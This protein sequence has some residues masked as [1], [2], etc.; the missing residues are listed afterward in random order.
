MPSSA[1]STARTWQSFENAAVADVFTPAKRSAVM[2]GI[3]SRANA[4]TELA[5]ARAMRASGVSGW[6]RHL[7]I[8]VTLPTHAR[9]IPAG[10]KTVRPDFVFRRAKVVV[11][12]DGC[13]WHGC[14]QHCSRPTTNSAWWSRKLRGNMTRDRLHTRLLTASGWKVLRLWEHALRTDADAC[15]ARVCRLL[16]RRVP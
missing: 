2:S 12:V 5:L 8:R 14:P 6:R 11:F 13:F 10:S 16:A 15:A 7:S 4:S 9:R 3:R 1:P